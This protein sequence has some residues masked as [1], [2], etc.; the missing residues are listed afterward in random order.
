MMQNVDMYGQIMHWYLKG[1]HWCYKIRGKK[2]LTLCMFAA[3]QQKHVYTYLHC[4]TWKSGR[5]LFKTP[6]ST[7]QWSAC[8]PK[9][10]GAEF[11]IRLKMKERDRICLCATRRNSCCNYT[12]YSWVVV[13]YSESWWTEGAISGYVCSCIKT[14]LKI[15]LT[16]FSW[17]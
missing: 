10:N 14:F 9:Q 15:C 5:S 7:E 3:V 16:D 8:L 12:F 6:C 11:C 4:H 13:K 2:E 1:T 17:K